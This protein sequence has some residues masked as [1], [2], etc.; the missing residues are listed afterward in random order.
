MVQKAE[1]RAASR[2]NFVTNTIHKGIH[3]KQSN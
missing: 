1:F 3:Y 2:D